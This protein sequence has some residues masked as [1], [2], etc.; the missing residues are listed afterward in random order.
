M[1]NTRKLCC[2]ASSALMLVLVGV[3]GAPALA[4]DYHSARTAG[5]GGAGHAGPLLNDS[6]ILN[7]A[8]A[9]FLPTYSISGSYFMG[10]ASTEPTKAHGYNLAFQDGRSKVFQAGASFSR[11]EDG[12]FI[13]LGASRSFVKRMG[14]GI[15]G[16]FHFSDDHSLTSNSTLA[17]A[18]LVNEWFQASFILDNLIETEN[19]KRLGQYREVILGTKFNIKG[20]MM[21]YFD[22]HMIP[23]LKGGDTYGYEAGAELVV[24][25]DIFVRGGMFRNA[26]V[27][28]ERVHGR[29]YGLGVGYIAP[30]LSLDYGVTM[31]REPRSSTVHVFGFTI[32]F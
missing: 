2:L 4:S 20:I 22:P 23:S 31:M 14:F 12:N 28:A 15:G 11:R 16:K 6:I 26:M 25:S 29:G 5:L 21:L 3:C 18:G 10:R 8:Y 13:H 7:P 27:P 17:V 9:S 1:W 30:K 24:M 19:S 32:F